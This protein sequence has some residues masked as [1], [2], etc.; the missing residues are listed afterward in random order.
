MASDRDLQAAL[1]AL[2]PPG[3]ALAASW[4]CPADASLLPDEE[5]YTTSMVEKRRREFRHGRHCARIAL[6]ELGAPESPIAKNDD[7][8]PQW[9]DGYTGSI[10]HTG[11]MAAAV[12]ARTGSLRALGLDIESPEPLDPGTRKMILRD[13][14]NAASGAEA[15]LLFSIKEAIYKCIYPLVQTYVDFREMEVQLDPASGTYRAQP[16]THKVTAEIAASLRGR[17]F[18]CETYVASSAWLDGRQSGR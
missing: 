13:E 11:E 14:E 9:P 5:Q 15:K 8:S 7:R 10:S 1:S 2:Y 3:V 18:V 16:H 4:R 17:Y 6:A 12:A